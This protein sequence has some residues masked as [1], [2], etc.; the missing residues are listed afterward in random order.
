MLVSAGNTYV[1]IPDDKRQKLD[2]KSK[3]YIV[4]G[5]SFEQKGYINA[6]TP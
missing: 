3:K 4:V 6:S 5:Y 2:L 1:H